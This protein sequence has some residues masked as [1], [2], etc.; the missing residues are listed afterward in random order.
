M[1]IKNAILRMS[2]PLLRRLLIGL[3]AVFC[4]G[5]VRPVMAMS[6]IMMEQQGAGDS[7]LLLLEKTSD[8]MQRVDLLNEISFS[9][10]RSDTDLEEKYAGDAYDLAKKI[11]YV[12]GEI[13]ALK[14][15]GNAMGKRGIAVDSVVAVFQD[16]LDRATKISDYKNMM[17]CNNNIGV[18][19]DNAEQYVLAL[20]YYQRA[21]E[22]HEEHLDMIWSR[23]LVLGN[24]G[25]IYYKLGHVEESKELFDEVMRVSVENGFDHVTDAFYSYDCRA[26]YELG[27]KNAL[28]ELDTHLERLEREDDI[29]GLLDGYLVKIKI[30]SDEDR[31]NDVYDYCSEALAVKNS[32]EFETEYCELNKW[33]VV[34]LSKIGKHKEALAARAVAERC[35]Q[36]QSNLRYQIEINS[37]ALKSNIA[38]GNFQKAY[39]H[40][41]DIE[42]LYSISRNRQIEGAYR[43]SEAKSQMRM[44]HNEVEMLRDREKSQSVLMKYLTIAL[45]GFTMMTLVVTYFNYKRKRAVDALSKQNADLQRAEMNLELKNQELEK[46]IE[47][48]IQLQQF[49]HI[50]SHDLKSPVRTI[51]SFIG[52]LKRSAGQ[53]LESNENMYIEM[54]ED[55]A[56][57]MYAL[58]TDLLSYSK[59]NALDLNISKV[60]A[61][62]IVDTVLRQLSHTI[63][64][65]QAEI[66]INALPTDRIAVD[67]LK[68]KQVFQN[69]IANGLKFVEK[70]AKPKIVIDY[71]DSGH[72]HQF[73]ISDNGIG[74]SPEFRE[75][76]FAPFK[77]LN[78]KTEY[79]GTGLGL[80]LVQ[81]IIEKHHG[82]I[83]IDDNQPSG[84]VFIFEISKHLE[85]TPSES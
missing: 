41:S 38:E 57:D 36:S 70:G 68:M 72:F 25:L 60:D 15:K 32:D 27:D 82:R 2:I 52:L 73:S 58:I 14:N 8:D 9:Y 40:A 61:N 80:S 10:N 48:N 11:G 63:S 45:L 53:K 65:S 31:W 17:A 75:E 51:S 29:N 4:I 69:L 49:A 76:V 43:E 23:P 6:V 21:Y 34:S 74:V 44:R 19:Y 24:V 3:V 13:T 71:K 26:R 84:C 12:S 64:E 79:S 55:G 20:E 5:S 30:A 37:A 47:S 85:E 59:A 28:A 42:E 78:T 7:L 62:E 46:Y 77:R 67:E 54:I 18:I 33:L 50:A 66:S 83:W 1:L 39:Q 16:A 35:A 56:N 22:I 81:K